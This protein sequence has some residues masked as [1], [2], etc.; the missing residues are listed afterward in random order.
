MK[1]WLAKCH[2]PKMGG[3]NVYF[4][5]D[6]PLTFM[7]DTVWVKE[8]DMTQV[9]DPTKLHFNW[10]TGYEDAVEVKCLWMFDANRG[11]DTFRRVFTGN[12]QPLRFINKKRNEEIA[13]EIEAEILRTLLEERNQN[14]LL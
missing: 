9:L 1:T 2:N 12:S 4:V 7:D 14:K 6:E 11:H 13:R 8:S 10:E 3:T 5:S